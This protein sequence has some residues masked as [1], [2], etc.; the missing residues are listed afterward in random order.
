MKVRSSWRVL[1]SVGLLAGIVP[2]ACAA[3]TESDAHGSSTAAGAD[4]SADGKSYINVYDGVADTMSDTDMDRDGV[5]NDRDLCPGSDSTADA[6]GC[7]AGQSPDAYQAPPN[8]PS[9]DIPGV[10]V[11]GNGFVNLKLFAKGGEIIEF[12]T[13]LENIEVLG[14]ELLVKGTLLVKLGDGSY[15]CLPA[16]D[17]KFDIDVQGLIDVHGEVSV[18]IPHL[19]VLGLIC[20]DAD[21][22]AKLDLVVDESECEFPTLIDS[23]HAMLRLQVEADVEAA[24]GPICIDLPKVDATLLVD[25]ELSN[26]WLK[27]PLAGPLL[28]AEGDVWV[29]LSNDEIPTCEEDK[30]MLGIDGAEIAIDGEIDFGKLGLDVDGN[31]YVKVND[32][33]CHG[34][35]EY[36]I[37]TDDG[38]YIGCDGVQRCDAGA[39]PDHC[40]GG[41][42]DGCGA[43]GDNEC[44]GSIEINACVDVD[45]EADLFGHEVELE[46]LEAK[47]EAEI[48]CDDAKAKIEGHLLHEKGLWPEILPL[49]LGV[50]A[51]IKAELFNHELIKVDVWGKIHFEASELECLSPLEDLTILDA[52]VTLLE[53]ETIVKGFVDVPLLDAI[54]IKHLTPIIITLPNDGHGFIIDVL[55]PDSFMGLP[56]LGG[57]FIRIDELGPH[58]LKGVL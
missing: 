35:S 38:C 53:H 4:D 8:A 6:N 31:V 25:A 5:P 45:L 42:K 30:A 24:V 46:I 49:G 13:L 56:V 27:G 17:V 48:G 47:V 54:G 2:L 7:A 40:D 29:G 11:L 37:E 55:K 32:D 10:D 19:G 22:R 39:P 57:D 1:A 12:R 52:E 14:S 9:F 15:L 26:F 41:G 36:P 51:K 18:K 21:V 33:E 20:V 16:A 50:D 58:L 23:I 44:C 34:E 28:A 43:C 3:P